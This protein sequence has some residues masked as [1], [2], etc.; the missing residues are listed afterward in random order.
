V[1]TGKA[2]GP[3]VDEDIKTYPVRIFGDDVQVK[4]D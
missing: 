4:V 2:L 3:P 1:R